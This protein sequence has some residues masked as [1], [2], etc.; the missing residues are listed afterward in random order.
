MFIQRPKYLR[1]RQPIESFQSQYDRLKA[2]KIQEFQKQ[3]E[4]QQKSKSDNA[5]DG[6][7]KPNDAVMAAD[8]AADGEVDSN[9]FILTR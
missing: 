6:V 1:G 3:Q 9:G 4:T 7:D 2:E 8:G 5:K